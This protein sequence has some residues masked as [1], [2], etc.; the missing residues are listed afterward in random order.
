MQIRDR[1]KELRR[2][3]AASLRPNARNW[4]THPQAQQEALRGLLAE[5]GYADALI[6]RE[7][8]DGGLELVDGHLRAETTPD[9][10]VPVL[11]LDVTEEEAKKLLV[12]L[13][14]LA[15]MA[16]ADSERL[17]ALLREVSTQSPGVEAMLQRLARTSGLERAGGEVVEDEAPEPLPAA[18]SKPG[19]L[20]RLGEHRLLCGDSTQAEHIQRI[21][22]GER[23]AL[24]ATDPPYLVEYTGE[25]PKKGDGSGG[26]KDW[27]ATY[28][29]IEITDADRFFR[30][31]FTGI[32]SVLAPHAAI[33]CWHAHKRQGLIA[34]I[35]EE[36]EIL[37]HQQVIWVKPTA[38]YGRVFWHFRH[39]PCM[40]G[41]A[42]GSMP[43]HDDDHRFDSVWEI[44]WEG[45]NRVVGNEHPTQKPVE[46][47]ARPM[48]KHTVPGDVCFEPFSGSGTQLIAAEQTGRR[49][50]AI[51][52]EPVFVDVAIRRWQTLTG[53]EAVLDAKGKPQSW[54]TVAA[55][56][57]IDVNE[58][59]A[60][61]AG[62]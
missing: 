25:R 51:E 56:R 34:R 4:R 21:M 22:G 6:A 30:A 33:Y 59:A 58:P 60:P 14:P 53:T 7:L 11:I 39:E 62:V 49:C 12:S 52:L 5:I 45:K 8:P 61:A 23:A 17:G 37:D 35:W 50:R 28:K 42:K 40:M 18:V 16:G 19:D 1:I 3:P 13:D 36:L 15:A 38:V 43:K 24:V 29:E 9:A 57:G 31:V 27:S 41:W 44:N 48:R 20:W 54:K 47:F 26:G 10:Q 55:K 46:L 2:V 32:L